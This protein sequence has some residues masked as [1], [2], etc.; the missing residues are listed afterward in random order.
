MTDMPKSNTIIW[1]SSFGCYR[2]MPPVKG[3][4]M[5]ADP[6]QHGV[7]RMRLFVPF[8]PGSDT[9]GLDDA[10]LLSSV[11]IAQTYEQAAAAYNRQIDSRIGELEREIYD[12]RTKRI[13]VTLPDTAKN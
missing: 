13:P 5:D 7:R 3:A 6:K 9:P 11:N 10:V 12:L 2:D 8:R 1:A 4:V